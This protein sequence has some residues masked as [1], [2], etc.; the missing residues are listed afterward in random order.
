MHEMIDLQKVFPAAL[1]KSCFIVVNP[2]IGKLFW[3]VDGP[4]CTKLSSVPML[5]FK[6]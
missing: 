1:G 6:L 5:A 4:A 2:T 3:L